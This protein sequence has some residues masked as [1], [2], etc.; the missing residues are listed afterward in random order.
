MNL[1]DKKVRHTKFGEGTITEQ[2]DSYVV[3]QFIS[4]AGEKKFIYPI[5][6]KSFLTLLD[7]ETASSAAN[8]IRQ[9]EK[10]ER[11][12]FEKKLLEEADRK[13]LCQLKGGGTGN[14]P[15]RGSNT[16][17]L[18]PFLNVESFCNHYESQLIAEIAYLRANG[19]KRQRVFDGT[20]IEKNNGKYLYSF[21]ADSELNYPDGTQ[22]T[23]WA[24]TGSIPGSIV[25]C[26][27][28]TLIIAST[29]NLSEK[30]S[31]IEFSAEPWMLL[32]SLIERLHKLRDKTNLPIVQALVCEGREQMK[33][34]A[35]IKKGQ[36]NACKMA[37]SQP[38]TFVWGPPGTG[39][40]ETLAKIA[41]QHIHRGNRVLMLSYSNVSVDGAILRVHNLDKHRVA[42]KLVRYGY[43]RDKSLLQH[44][45]LTSY[46]LVIHKHPDLL[47]ERTK[48]LNERKRF[49][50]VQKA[51]PR[52]VEI[53]KRLSQ[54]R[55]LLLEEEKASVHSAHFVAT[56]VSKAIADKTVYENT[57]DVVIFDEASMAY[58]PQIVFS[59]S[60]TQKHF[61]C[62]GDFAQLPPIV[63]N[64]SDAILN[65]DIFRYCGI[66]LDYMEHNSVCA[67]DGEG[68]K[69]AQVFRDC[70][71]DWG[72]YDKATSSNQQYW[73][74]A[75]LRELEA[76]K[77]L[78][79]DSSSRQWRLS[80]N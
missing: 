31:S 76:Q 3:V 36:D 28:F 6:F 75:L 69:Q 56:T 64:G 43:A 29:T 27:D 48:L 38:I 58:V 72:S 35:D 26:E 47:N 20:L 44:E 70:G 25:C 55:N 33:Y 17:P 80:S 10:E 40:T 52:Y 32:N 41:L 5:C 39:K 18:R 11:D 15:S 65:A 16:P 30:V 50:T 78:E 22:I 57:F 1:L 4:G 73:V 79:Q 45:Y 60:L 74:V 23:I 7:S 71:L 9:R 67:P 24:A 59:A 54:I 13:A 61:I 34:G 2:S 42:G 66:V 8:V 49:S 63:Q 19:G 12:R 68:I 51:S 37:L 77:I 53:Q 14:R 62:M 46:N 21:E